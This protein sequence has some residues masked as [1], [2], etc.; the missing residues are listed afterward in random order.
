MCFKLKFKIY[1]Q[2]FFGFKDIWV[3]NWFK[4]KCHF[5]F[6]VDYSGTFIGNTVVSFILNLD[7]TFLEGK[8]RGEGG[9]GIF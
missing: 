9:M 3:I 7:I 5:I 4:K 1:V 2:K 8:G 6:G